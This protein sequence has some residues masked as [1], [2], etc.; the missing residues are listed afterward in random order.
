MKRK[1][2]TDKQIAYALLPHREKE[3]LAR[4][5]ATMVAGL[6]EN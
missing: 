2:Y 5:A 1:R 6:V 3:I 4:G